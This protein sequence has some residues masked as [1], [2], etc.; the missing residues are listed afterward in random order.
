[1]VKSDRG[2]MGVDAVI[3]KDLAS[4]LLARILEVDKFVILTDVKGVYRN[5]GGSQEEFIPEISALDLEGELQS[6]IFP[7]GS[8]GPKARA[9]LEFAKVTGK[10]AVIG[11][12]DEA[13]MV[14]NGKAGTII[15]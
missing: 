15:H 11:S 12:L 8:M 7:K 14:I 6:G 10:Q 9:A 4:S 3:D 13:G 5:Y 1:M 2:Y